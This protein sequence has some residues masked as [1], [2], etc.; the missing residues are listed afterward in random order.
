MSDEHKARLDK[1]KIAIMKAEFDNLKS[2]HSDSDM[3]E[4]IRKI[5]IE[6]ANK[7]HGGKSNVD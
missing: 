2:P 3:V 7:I 6:E 4:K 5:I 1:M